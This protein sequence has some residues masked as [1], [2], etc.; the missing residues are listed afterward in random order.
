MRT[1]LTL[2][3]VLAATMAQAQP[4]TLV[5][6]KLYVACKDLNT[7]TRYR[8]LLEANDTAAIAK[9]AEEVN[10]TKECYGIAEG[11]TLYRDD[12]AEKAECVRIQGDTTCGWTFPIFWMRS[13]REIIEE[14]KRKNGSGS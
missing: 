3:F 2:S 7:W 6:D 5:L 4:E 8:K 14:H 12:I 13:A 9:F 11:T 10:K 1:V